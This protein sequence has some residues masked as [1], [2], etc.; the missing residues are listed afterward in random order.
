MSFSENVKKELTELPLKLTCCRKAFVY[1]LLINSF[2]EAENKIEFSCESEDIKDL[3]SGIFL[4]QFKK[5]VEISEKN[6]FGHKRYI[7]SFSSASAAELLSR[8]VGTESASQLIGFRCESCRMHF[9]R[10]AFLSGGTVSDPMKSYHLEFTVSD[11]KRAKLFFEEL[12]QAGFE[13]KISNRKN[14]I[15]LYFK[16]SGSIED[17]LTYLGASK[18]LFECMNDKILREIRNDSNRRA[19]CETGNIRKSVN[20]SQDVIAAIKKLEASGLLAALPDDLRET[21]GIRMEMPEASL[22]EMCEKFSPTLSKSGLSH[23]FERI[24][25]FAED[26]DKNSINAGS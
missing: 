20:A 7:L 17:I 13:A 12:R 2:P 22:S 21:A 14:G 1:G 11:A 18:M 5:T 3:V 24:K 16:D 25:K 26:I 4:D 6:R 19:N 23:R 9:L 8:A 10:G 15:G